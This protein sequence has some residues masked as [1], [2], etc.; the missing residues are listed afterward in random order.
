MPDWISGFVLTRKIYLLQFQMKKIQQICM[1]LYTVIPSYRY[2]YFAKVPTWWSDSSQLIGFTP[3]YGI[4]WITGASAAGREW[5]I[6]DRQVEMMTSRSKILYDSDSVSK[7]QTLYNDTA[8]LLRFRDFQIF[9][10]A[11]DGPPPKISSR[12]I[13]CASAYSDKFILKKL[14]AKNIGH[15]TSIVS[16]L[17]KPIVFIVLYSYGYLYMYISIGLFS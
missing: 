12:N 6:A 10:H 14:H 2:I 3:F 7:M 16:N 17:C 9:F 13:K 15:R 11:F 8:A 4:K 1:F 5:G